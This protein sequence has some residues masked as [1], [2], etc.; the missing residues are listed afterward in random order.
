[1]YLGDGH[2]VASKKTWILRIYQ[3]AKYTNLVSLAL[4]AMKSCWPKA[5]VWSGNQGPNCTLCLVRSPEIVEAFPQHGPGR[6]HLRPIVLADWQVQAV[7]SNAAEFLRG[8]IHSDGCRSV[9]K[10]PKNKGGTYLYPFY[11]F[12]NRSSDILNLCFWVSDLLGLSPTRSSQVMISFAKRKDVSLMDT[13][14][15]PKS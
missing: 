4:G 14:I 9:R 10:I 15:G 5:T 2:I 7:R 6:K 11:G 13:W 8:L 12:S 1:L 3:T